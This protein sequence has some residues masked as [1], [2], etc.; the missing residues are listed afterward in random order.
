MIADGGLGASNGGA[1]DE[2]PDLARSE[3]IDEQRIL[4]LSKQPR[5]GR[6]GSEERDL[7]AT[8]RVL[9][10]LHGETG[11]L[12]MP[13]RWSAALCVTA[14]QVDSSKQVREGD[15]AEVCGQCPIARECSTALAAGAPVEVRRWRERVDGG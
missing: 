8:A 5:S 7:A 14:S 4:A 2:Q 13:I 3:V 15:P 12:A 6:P 1:G 11:R 10:Y 9:S